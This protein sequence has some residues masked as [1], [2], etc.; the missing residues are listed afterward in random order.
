MK[1]KLKICEGKLAILKDLDTKKNHKTNLHH[2]TH[3]SG[4]KL[5]PR[6]QEYKT[7]VLTT[8]PQH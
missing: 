4:Q 1:N 5:N 7:T 3:I 6:L 8:E 2:I